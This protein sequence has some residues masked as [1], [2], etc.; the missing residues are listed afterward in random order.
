MPPLSTYAFRLWDYW[1]RNLDPDLFRERSLSSSVGGKVE[2]LVALARE[3]SRVQAYVDGAEV[4]R[5]FVAPGKKLVNF[6]T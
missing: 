6:V 2:E 4:V 3:S 5:T 1:E